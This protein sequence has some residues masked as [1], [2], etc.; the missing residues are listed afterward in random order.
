MNYEQEQLIQQAFENGPKLL[1]NQQI[2]E[3]F[4][5]VY[6]PSIWDNRLQPLMIRLTLGTA[7]I[8]KLR[9]DQVALLLSHAQ[10]SKQPLPQ[11]LYA[12]WL[13]FNRERWTETP[14]IARMMRWAAD[15]GI[16]DAAWMLRYLSRGGEAGKIDLEIADSCEKEAI[17]KG[18]VK[19]YLWQME[20]RID[21]VEGDELGDLIDEFKERYAKS[22]DPIFLILLAKALIK[23]CQF[24]MAEQ[25]AR[26]AIDF[27]IVERGYECLRDI[28]TRDE[29]GEELD[30][31]NWDWDR[32]LPILEEGASHD[33][34]VSM[35]LL[36]LCAD[37]YGC[38][39]TCRLPQLL[40]RSA[41]LGY[42]DSCYDL[43]LAF[44]E[45]K[46][47]LEQ[48]MEQ[49]WNWF[50]RGAMCGH[51]ESFYQLYLVSSYAEDSSADQTY[52]AFYNTD[53]LKDRMP[54]ADWKRLAETVFEGNHV[55]WMGDYD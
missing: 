46:Y 35:N 12:Y 41:Q 14:I 24:D 40:Q 16:G 54:A 18:S 23:C 33:D 39:D 55:E 8:N 51:T 15:C 30:Y 31:E 42:G 21:E 2:P 34:P 19:A 47:G 28:Y 11:Y 1:A 7:P 44:N 36:V 53:R 43:A 9:D 48:D 25:C 22:E 29:D 10:S 3:F 38:D 5:T 37:D 26:R 13:L 32:L 52:M 17:E 49:V 27:G 50:H 4:D 45:G 20:N 6:M